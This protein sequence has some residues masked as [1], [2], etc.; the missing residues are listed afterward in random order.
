VRGFLCFRSKDEFYIL[1][2]VALREEAE[3]G[4]FDSSAKTPNRSSSENLI[5]LD[6]LDLIDEVQKRIS[7]LTAF[8]VISRAVS[9]LYFG[10]FQ[11]VK[12]L[13]NPVFKFVAFTHRSSHARIDA[14][15]SI[16]MKIE[17]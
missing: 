3:R 11:V 2:D 4:N 12:N 10:N 5:S 14:T 16:G 9:T 7:L 15:R 6:E 1:E 17:L 13:F 8:R